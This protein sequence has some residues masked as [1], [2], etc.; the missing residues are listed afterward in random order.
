MFK[1]IATIKR[2]KGMT[3]EAFI[4]YYENKHIP[5]IRRTIGQTYIYRRNYVVYEDPILTVVRSGP[6]FRQEVAAHGGGIEDDD[7]D[8][9]SECIFSTREDAQTQLSRFADPEIS[10][11]IQEDEAKFCE[12]GRSKI[13]IVEVHQCPIP[14]PAE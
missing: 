12:P 8:V 3:R 11:I 2:K 6:T 10:R 4:D 7:F 13:Y 5:L 14:R 1:W 9:L